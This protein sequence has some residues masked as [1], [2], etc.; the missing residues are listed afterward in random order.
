MWSS[1]AGVF[2]SVLLVW[3]PCW[4]SRVQLSRWWGAEGQVWICN[5]TD[6]MR[7]CLNVYSFTS[8]FIRSYFNPI[9]VKLCMFSMICVHFHLLVLYLL[10]LY[11]KIAINQA[12]MVAWLQ[13]TWLQDASFGKEIWEHCVSYSTSAVCILCVVSACGNLRGCTVSA[14]LS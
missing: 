7:R 4:V 3:N 8:R 5:F 14:G 11:L 10:T 2:C 1:S 13:D 12:S 9:L 6:K